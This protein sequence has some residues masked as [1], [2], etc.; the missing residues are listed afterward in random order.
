MQIT[1]ATIIDIL[2]GVC[3][4]AAVVRG[5]FTGLIMKLAQLVALIASFV[6]AQCLAES[7]GKR[8]AEEVFLPAFGDVTEKQGDST[9]LT[10]VAAEK[11]AEQIA[12]LV[13]FLIAFC[14]LALVLRHLLAV[15][16]LVDKIPVIGF[17][18]RVGGAVCGVLVEFLIFYLIIGLIFGLMPPSLLEEWG[19]TAEAVKQ[20]VLL[21]VFVPSA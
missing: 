17:V 9:L 2:I 21:R 14:I 3:L 1:I 19:L 12:Y 11:M 6:A 18:N 5:Y 15:L 8:L 4:I 10:Q 20:T 13:I 16:K 7:V